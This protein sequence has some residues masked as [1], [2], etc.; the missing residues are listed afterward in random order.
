VRQVL[1]YV[2]TGNV[3]SGLVYATDAQASDQVQV[4]AIAPPETHTPIVYPVA[5]VEASDQQ[6]AAQAFVD[7]A[8][9]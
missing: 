6:A 1:A 8:I 9:E 7:F 4:M 3:D 5:V 2:E